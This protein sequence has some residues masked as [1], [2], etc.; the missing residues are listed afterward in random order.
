[1]QNDGSF[2]A[3]SISH[4]L[5]IIFLLLL[6]SHIFLVQNR[7]LIIFLYATHFFSTDHTVPGLAKVIGSLGSNITLKFTFNSSVDLSQGGDI[8][9]HKLKDSGKERVASCTQGKGGHFFVDPQ[10]RTVYWDKTELKMTD[11]GTYTASIIQGPATKSESV[12][13]KV[14]EPNISTTG[15][16]LSTRNIPPLRSNTLRF[17]FLFFWERGG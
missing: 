4:R 11:S 9:I 5:I 16:T 15:R 13:L 12:I 3:K 1:M 8:V 10:T 7:I 2:M 14:E 6:L 17:F